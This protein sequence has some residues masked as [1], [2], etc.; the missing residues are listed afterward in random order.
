MRQ[1]AL[2][3]NLVSGGIFAIPNHDPS[4]RGKE[5]LGA[6][7]FFTTAPSWVLGFLR[8]PPTVDRNL[9]ED[10][11]LSYAVFIFTPSGMTPSLT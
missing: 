11:N 8:I 9:V 3:A 6:G 10:E 7:P 5:F 2:R 1:D 4:I